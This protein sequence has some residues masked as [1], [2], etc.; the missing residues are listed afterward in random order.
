MKP[1]IISIIGAPGVGKS[2]LTE[3][4]AKQLDAEFII[5]DIE[6]VPKRIIENLK[7]NIRP[8]ETVLW[9]RNIY[10]KNIE[11][12][13]ILKQKGKI[14]VTDSCLITNELHI[15]TMTVGFKQKIISQQAKF[16]KKYIPKPD[17]IIFLDASD[18]VIKNFTLSRNRDFDT[19][20]DYIKRNLSISRAHKKYYQKNKNSLVYINRDS[21]D[22]NK[23]ED[24]LKVIDKIKDKHV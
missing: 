9:F 13:H 3:R 23:K 20:N 12:A 4:L 22:F 5:E 16:D 19:N 11:K 17:I 10:I 21:L 1:V 6:K 18:K 15:T 14:V 2:F 8:M 24:L 7:N